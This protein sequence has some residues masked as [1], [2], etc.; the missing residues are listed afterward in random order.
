M[1]RTQII[2]LTAGAITTLIVF[3][4]A[5]W[6]L[7]FGGL[8]PE[9]HRLIFVSIA[10]GPVAMISVMV[11]YAVWWLVMFVLSLFSPAGQSSGKN[12]DQDRE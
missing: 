6:L 2:A 10:L 11:G 8:F 7:V 9:K 12:S 3:V 4:A 5:M 1:T